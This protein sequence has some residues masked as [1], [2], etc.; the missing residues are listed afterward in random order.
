MTDEFGAFNPFDETEETSV[1]TDVPVSE[2]SFEEAPN[3]DIAKE[4]QERLDEIEDEYKELDEDL[5]D[6]D[7]GEDTMWMIQRVSIGILKIVGVVG[8]VG[9]ILWTI[10]GGDDNSSKTENKNPAKKIVKIEKKKNAKETDKKK[11]EINKK[12]RKEESGGF[13]SK[14]FSGGNANE[15]EKKIEKSDKKNNKVE[16]KKEEVREIPAVVYQNEANYVENNQEKKSEQNFAENSS[17]NLA[18]IQ[19]MAWNYWLEKDRLLGQKNTPGEVALWTKDAESLFDVPFAEQVKGRNDFERE[20]KVKTLV[21]D[22]TNLLKKAEN[23]QNKLL[24]EMREYEIKE[25][26]YIAEATEY[27]RL[28]LEAMNKSDPAGIDQFLAKK[29]EAEK[30]QLENGIEKESR[31]YLAEKIDSYA[32]VLVNLREYL[33]ANRKA[34]VKDVQVV[35]FPEDPF[36]RIIP[37][38]TWK[39]LRTKK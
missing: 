24:A 13:F 5:L 31:Q 14:L 26:S 33:I 15:N 3:E 37:L 23:L 30:K 39:Q 27:E 2:V 32:Q 17:T 4:D 36:H 9:L 1:K 19:I 20:K 16:T 10:W 18:T 28:F 29:I 21:T 11:K 12:S 8:I 35:Q 7:D 25:K 6:V 34:L 38:E 22:S